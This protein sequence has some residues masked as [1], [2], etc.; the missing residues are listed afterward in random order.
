MASITIIFTSE[1]L[2]KRSPLELEFDCALFSQRS[3]VS[4]HERELGY[5]IQRISLELTLCLTLV[6]G[7]RGLELTKG[8][9]EAIATFPGC[10]ATF[11][12]PFDLVG[13]F[14][15]YESYVHQGESRKSIPKFFCD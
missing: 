13:K 11:N 8:P 10:P 5:V 12:P 9:M 6:D 1:V 2:L 7:T 4:L 3:C 15:L 14:Q